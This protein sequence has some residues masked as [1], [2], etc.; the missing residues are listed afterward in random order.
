MAAGWDGRAHLSKALWIGLAVDERGNEVGEAFAV[1]RLD[2]AWWGCSVGGPC[3][4][5]PLC[6]SLA[7]RDALSLGERPGGAT[8]RSLDRHVTLIAVRCPYCPSYVFIFTSPP[9]TCTA[10]PSKSC[11][12]SAAYSNPRALAWPMISRPEQ[13]SGDTISHDPTSTGHQRR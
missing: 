3:R 10:L 8:L 5:L 6:A 13:R 11:P 2:F 4:S 7:C 1:M 9:R 12:S